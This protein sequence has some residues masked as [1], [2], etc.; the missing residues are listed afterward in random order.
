MRTAPAGPSLK[1]TRRSLVP[2]ITAF[3][4]AA[5][6]NAVRS[7]AP[8]STGAGN[9]G[10]S[11]DTRVT[12]KDTVKSIHQIS[13]FALPLTFN[14]RGPESSPAKLTLNKLVDPAFNCREAYSEAT[15]WNG[16]N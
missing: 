1:L 2:G 5:S 12:L 11:P 16:S 8:T 3:Q 6:A 13:N 14:G 10:F 15:K 4:L 9:G 7:S